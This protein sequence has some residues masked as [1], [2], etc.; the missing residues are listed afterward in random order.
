MGL[1]GTAGTLEP[2]A[3]ADLVA[4]ESNPLADITNTRQIYGVWMSGN[5]IR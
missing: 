2:G 1:S 4:V 5:R 3:Q